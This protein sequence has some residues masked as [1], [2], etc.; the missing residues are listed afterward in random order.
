MDASTQH[1]FDYIKSVV[2]AAGL[3]APSEV[4]KSDPHPSG[5]QGVM[6][7]WRVDGKIETKAFGNQV[8]D[9]LID[10]LKDWAGSAEAAEGQNS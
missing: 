9:A 2:D 3:G 6:L 10:A 5:K 4:I 8:P 1:D 7:L